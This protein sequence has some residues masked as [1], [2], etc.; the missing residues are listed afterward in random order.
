MAVCEQDHFGQQVEPVQRVDD[1]AGL[2]ARVHHR[3]APAVGFPQD[4]TV[5]AKHGDRDGG[6]LEGWHR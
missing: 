5:L 3:A 4:R 6:D 1:P 2:A